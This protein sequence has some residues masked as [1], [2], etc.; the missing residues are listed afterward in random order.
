MAKKSMIARDVKRAKLVAKY[1]DK[2]AALKAKISDPETTFEERYAI[3]LDCA[4]DGQGRDITT[5][6]KTYLKTFDQWLNNQPGD[7]V[8]DA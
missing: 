3:Y 5:N 4:D 7:S 2:R 8:E 1:A 6:G